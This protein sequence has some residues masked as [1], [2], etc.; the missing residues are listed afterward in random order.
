[1][2]TLGVIGISF[3]TDNTSATSESYFRWMIYT[4]DNWAE[5]K[6]WN[7]T[8]CK[9]IS[10]WKEYATSWCPAGT[11]LSSFSTIDD[12]SSARIPTVTSPSII[13]PPTNTEMSPISP[14]RAGGW[15]AATEISIPTIQPTTTQPTTTPTYIDINLPVADKILQIFIDKHPDIKQE[16][17]CVWLKYYVDKIVQQTN[18]ILGTPN[19]ER[20]TEIKS[21]FEKLLYT[22]LKDILGCDTI[23]PTIRVENYFR[24][25]V[26]ACDNWPE[27][28]IRDETSCKPYSAW[29]DLAVSQCSTADKLSTFISLDICGSTAVSSA[30]VLSAD[31]KPEMIEK[32]KVI[33]T[34]K[35]IRADFFKWISYTCS[36]WS[37]NQTSD[38]NSCQ[39]YS[40]LKESAVNYCSEKGGLSKLGVLEPCSPTPED[41]TEASTL[42][43][44]R[45]YDYATEKGITTQPTLQAANAQWEL[46]RGDMAKMIVNFSETV[47]DK[48]PD[49]SKSCIFNDI[50][51][52][53][54]EMKNY[55]IEACQLWLMW[56]WISNFYPND[57]VNRAQFA[58][59]LSRTLYGDTYEWGTVYYEG[60]LQALKSAD[61]IS[62]T[63][64][65][66]ASE[67]RSYVWMMLKRANEQVEW[68]NI[69]K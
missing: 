61:I 62:N 44:K 4:C 29:K 36:D 27:I 58:T 2:I 22:Y 10:L 11:I 60:H 17:S 6:V 66:L 49:T 59:T 51:A 13:V 55:I 68:T 33:E 63:T 20:E 57:I 43:T 45:A 48:T 65:P 50:A 7:A 14:T 34:P 12:C 8:S 53:S 46:T 32:A 15:Q 24:W 28:Q 18:I 21:Y 42:E 47:L 26:Y 38:E 16:I 31:E 5:T 40:L 39:L 52:Q 69:E 35:A 9:P 54:E 23:S 19:V 25:L 56:Q 3:A 64:T 67:I 30:V 41:K 37:E 1:M